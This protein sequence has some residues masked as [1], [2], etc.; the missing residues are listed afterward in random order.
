MP[1]GDLIQFW[2]LAGL[3]FS[4]IQV[5]GN[6][7]NQALTAM[8]GAERVFDLLDQQ[9]RVD[10]SSRCVIDLRCP[11]RGELQI[12]NVSFSYEPGRDGSA[13]MSRSR[14]PPE[15]MMALVGETGSGKS[16]LA[17][18]VARYYL[19]STGTDPFGRHRYAKRSRVS[20]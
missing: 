5:L 9:P 15:Q 14:S 4:P 12:E 6:Q 18:L 13:R 16:T 19:P 2:F 8:A 1:I 17:G 20:R 10:G 3:F 7:Y 11:A